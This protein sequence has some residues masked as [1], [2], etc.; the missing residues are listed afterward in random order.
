MMRWLFTLALW[1]SA[2]QC[3]AEI[4]KC[5]NEGKTVFSQAPCAPNAV[6]VNPSVY[7]PSTQSIREQQQSQKS[8][9]MM[10][11]GI[12]RDYGLLV[13]QRRMADAD[14]NIARLLSE[15]DQRI[16]AL[17]MEL[18]QVRQD[19]SGA[20]SRKALSTE[21][22]NLRDQYKT[23]IDLARG[24]LRRAEKEYSRLQRGR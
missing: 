16:A 2:P 13:L 10:S 21:I 5:V 3:Y 19:K 18:A 11:K 23:S 15:R 14:E 1:V 6:V 8:M 24:D 20:A 7:Q 9:E 12:D 22:S 4:Y 17:R